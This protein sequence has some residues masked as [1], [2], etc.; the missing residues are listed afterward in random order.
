MFGFF[1]FHSV[2]NTVAKEEKFQLKVKVGSGKIQI[3]YQMIDKRLDR[4]ETFFFSHQTL[5]DIYVLMVFRE[6]AEH[7][8]EDQNI[9]LYI[10]L[11]LYLFTCLYTHKKHCHM[12]SST[13]ILHKKFEFRSCS[14]DFPRYFCQFDY[15]WRCPVVWGWGPREEAIR[16]AGTRNHT[17]S[18]PRSSSPGN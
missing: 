9:Y 16:G 12:V 11:Y 3:Y 14:S 17:S 18:W 4:P 1:S 15:Q 7:D 13:L 6:T 8:E 2:K 5:T 10:C